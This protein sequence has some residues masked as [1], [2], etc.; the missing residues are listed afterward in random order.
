MTRKM[1][2]KPVETVYIT[3]PGDRSVGINDSC[4]RISEL[5]ID[6]KTFDDESFWATIEGFRNDLKKA[7]DNMLGDNG[8]RVEFDFELESEPKT[9]MREVIKDARYVSDDGTLVLKRDGESGR[10]RLWKYGSTLIDTDQY[11]NDITERNNLKLYD[12][13]TMLVIL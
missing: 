6:P 5:G 8:T 13:T 10:W 7:F 12:A 2:N 4:W 3:F 1:P 9:I 11:R